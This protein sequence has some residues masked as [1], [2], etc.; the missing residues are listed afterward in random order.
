MIPH[1]VEVFV[2]LIRSIFG[3]DSIACV[4]QCSKSSDEMRGRA[5]CSCSS[6]ATRPP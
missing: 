1:G 2:G 4:V 6:V 5:R 3:G